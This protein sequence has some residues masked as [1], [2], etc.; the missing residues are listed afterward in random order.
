N[1]RAFLERAENDFRRVKRYGDDLSVVMMD[2]DLFKQV[3]DLHGHAVGD[4][5]LVGI[6]RT[7]EGAIR[8]FDLVGRMGGEE[9]A[10]ILVH[11]AIED[12]AAC[13]E[14]IRIGIESLVFESANGPVRIT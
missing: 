10:I 5:V 13:A 2:A 6:A 4:A 11:T 3:N 7:A 9:F 14:R 8:S 1:R 12:A